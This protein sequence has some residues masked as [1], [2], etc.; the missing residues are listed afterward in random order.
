MPND[1]IENVRCTSIILA[2]ET[3]GPT[4]AYGMIG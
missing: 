1:P 3:A 2:N 4:Y